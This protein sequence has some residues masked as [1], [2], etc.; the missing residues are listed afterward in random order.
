[1]ASPRSVINTT[2]R[3]MKRRRLLIGGIFLAFLLGF[4]LF[5]NHGLVMRFKLELHERAINTEIERHQLR[6]D[7]LRAQI[8]TL[9]TD[10][11][12]IE[13]LARQ[14]YGLIKP[15]EEVYFVEPKK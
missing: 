6:R 13:R 15:N 12:E 7:S 9:T 11:L 3:L 4:I 10:T 8:R 5:T 2:K 1:M 14:N